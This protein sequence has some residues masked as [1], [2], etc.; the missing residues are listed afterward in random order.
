[1]SGGFTDITFSVAGAP[2]VLPSYAQ[3][4]LLSIFFGLVIGIERESRGKSASLRTFSIISGGSCLFTMLSIQSAEA[5][6]AAPFDYTRVAAQIVS[7][8]GFLGAGV[9]FKTT[10]RIEG[11]TTAALIWLAAALGMAC[12]FNAISMVLWSFAICILIHLLIAALYRV[13]YYVRGTDGSES[14]ESP[15]SH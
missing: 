11:I 9:I 14:Y 13:I 12:G 10:D 15:L 8:V 3:Q 2:W 5:F 6:V 7:G 4:F 1:M